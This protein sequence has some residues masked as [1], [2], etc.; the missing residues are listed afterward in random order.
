MSRTPFP[1]AAD[2]RPLSDRLA[3]LLERVC[4]RR[5]AHVLIVYEDRDGGQISFQASGVDERMTR[6]LEI[7]AKAA[8][9]ANTPHNPSA[10][11]PHGGIAPPPP[12]GESTMAFADTT[13]DALK[14][15]AA[16]DG[17]MLTEHPHEGESFPRLEIATNGAAAGAPVLFEAL[18]TGEAQAW[19]AGFEARR[20]LASEAMLAAERAGLTPDQEKA[21]KELL[22]ALAAR[23][24][25]HEG[26]LARTE[27]WL[28]R[29]NE[30]FGAMHSMFTNP[31]LGAPRDDALAEG[32]DETA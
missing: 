12:T 25:D 10:R 14:R 29:L 7:C 26:R 31:F 3:L 23:I 18:S 6:V 27:L 1:A 5:V 8:R 24:E 20:D 30:W 21:A 9:Q 13:I 2:L 22:L 15:R 17:L 16:E 11:Y 19:L 28:G 32:E 4:G